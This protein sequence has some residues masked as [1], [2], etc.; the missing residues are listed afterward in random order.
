MTTTVS[1]TTPILVKAA[2]IV[3]DM[4][5]NVH[6][7][8]NSTEFPVTI[9]GNWRVNQNPFT[10][11]RKDGILPPIIL[12]GGY[13]GKGLRLYAFDNA[14]FS[15]VQVNECS[16]TALEIKAFRQCNFE[17]VRLHRNNSPDCIFR[18]TADPNRY[19]TNMVNFG[20]VICMGNDA[21]TTIEMLT[22]PSAKNRLRLINIGMLVCH[23]TWQTLKDQFPGVTYPSA[24]A[25]RR[26]VHMDADDVTVSLFNFRLEPEDPITVRAIY[27]EATC[28]RVVFLNGQVLRRRGDTEDF[29]DGPINLSNAQLAATGKPVGYKSLVERNTGNVQGPVVINPFSS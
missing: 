11:D 4:I 23:P 24:R 9:E 13:K 25:N 12:N 28:Q 20:Q 1:V 29:V 8:Y 21:P 15:Q 10:E 14:D 18:I 16:G 6:S 5:Y 17:S 2:D 26:H 19:S 22:L 3:D 7:S 27:A